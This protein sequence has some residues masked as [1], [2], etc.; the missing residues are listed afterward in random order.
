MSEIMLRTDQMSDVELIEE[1]QKGSSRLFEVIIRRYNPRLF[2]IGMA[3]LG[4]EMDVEDA[5]QTTFIKVYQNLGKFERRSSFSTW[6]IRI[7]INE[8]L[9]WKKKFQGQAIY[10]EEHDMQIRD[11]VPIP[12]DHLLNKELGKA[13]EHAL[14]ELPEK[15]RLVFVLREMEDLSVKEAAAVMGIGRINVKVRLNRAKSMLKDKVSAF[16][17]TDAIYPFHLIRCDRIVKNVFQKLNIT[18]DTGI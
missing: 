13:L 12:D 8:C 14:S 11:H 9:A 1:I 15:Y 6:M 4:Q 16:Y 3:I 5:M 17:K 7:H 18:L 10:K 2:K